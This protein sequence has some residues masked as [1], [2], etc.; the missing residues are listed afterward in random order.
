MRE[1]MSEQPKPAPTASAIGPCSAIIQISRTPRHWKFTHHLRTT[2]P[3]PFMADIAYDYLAE[4]FMV[5]NKIVWSDMKKGPKAIAVQYFLQ[6]ASVLAEL[7]KVFH[8]P[9]I[10]F[11][12]FSNWF[13]YYCLK[14]ACHIWVS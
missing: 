12:G 4:I 1:K 5:N 8:F 3:P 14:C 7:I 9:I 13:G 6:V 10:N 2:R 11:Q